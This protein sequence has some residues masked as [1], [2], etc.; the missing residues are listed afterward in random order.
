MKSILNH[1]GTCPVCGL[2]RRI[3]GQVG[4]ASHPACSRKLQQL[5]TQDAEG[6]RK[7]TSRWTDQSTESLLRKVGA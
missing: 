4:V 6:K 2:P 5:H 7:T 3:P 1:G